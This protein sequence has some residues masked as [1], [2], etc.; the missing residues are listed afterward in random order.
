MDKAVSCPENWKMVAFETVSIGGLT[1]RNRIVMP[2]MNTELATED[3]E[4]TDQLIHHY[5]IR[6]P[7]LG[8]IIVEHS[9]VRSDGKASPRQ[10]G[11]YN[12]RL[13]RGLSQLASAVKDAGARVAIQLNHAGDLADPAVV[14]TVPKGPSRSDWGEGLTVKEI[15]ELIDCF[16]LAAERAVRSGYDII[17]IHGAHGYLL[18]Q[19]ASPLKNTRTDSYGGSLENRMR[20]PLE[21]VRRIRKVARSNVQIWYRLGADDRMPGGNSIQEGV[22]MSKLLAAE[23]VDV[24]DVSGGLCGPNPDGLGG[25]GY[26]SYAA[27]AVKNATNLPVVVAGG[28]TT[29]E[30]AQLVHAQGIDLVAVGRALLNDPMWAKKSQGK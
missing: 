21:V 8:L 15:G 25:P 3:G 9:Y 30:E 1:L 28:V 17:E 10:L 6:A 12:N 13:E 4:V 2:P 19:F 16:G 23:G 5:S 7:W 11:I 18:N 14:R 27:L 22:E 29:A 20:F 26:F 24:I